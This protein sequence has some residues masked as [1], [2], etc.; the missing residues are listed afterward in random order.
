MA[1]PA[2]LMAVVCLCRNARVLRDFARNWLPLLFNAFIGTDAQQREQ[3]AAAIAAYAT[4]AEPV[5]LSHFFRE[6]IKKLL[7]A[8]HDFH[9]QTCWLPFF[10]LFCLKNCRT[11]DKLACL[12]YQLLW[13]GLHVVLCRVMHCLELCADINHCI[14]KNL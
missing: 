7:K 3:Y 4:I 9:W 5:T 14:R 6:V 8:R 10:G 2:V 12:A 1:G 13:M 11:V